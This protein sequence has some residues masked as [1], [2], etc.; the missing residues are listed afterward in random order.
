[1]ENRHEKNSDM[2]WCGAPVLAAAILLS[3]CNTNDEVRTETNPKPW[4]RQAIVDPPS[5]ADVKAIRETLPAS[6]NS[7][8]SD[9]KGDDMRRLRRAAYTIEILAQDAVA[10]VPA[11]HEALS[12][13]NNPATQS[14][15]V[16][17]LAATGGNKE[18]VAI[19]KKFLKSTSHPIPRMYAACA[20]IVILGIVDDSKAELKYVLTRLQAYQSVKPP[21]NERDNENLRI[22]WEQC[23]AASHLLVRLGPAADAL[24][25][26]FE[27]LSQFDDTPLWLKREVMMTIRRIQPDNRT[28]R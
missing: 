24:T 3:A 4:R 14:Y 10:A 23:W 11:L 19:L 28:R 5:L 17:A 8:V 2:N 18:S 25:P 12:S 1:M 13:D 27:G 16:R 20:V 26:V 21:K 15:I 6:L 7:V 9:L 22:L